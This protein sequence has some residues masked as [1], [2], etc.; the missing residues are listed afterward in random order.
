MYDRHKPIIKWYEYD[1]RKLY[2]TAESE[3]ATEE[4][5]AS[6]VPSASAGPEASAAGE[7]VHGLTDA[8]EDTGSGGGAL[9]GSELDDEV[10]RIMAAFSGAKQNSVD[11]VFAMM[12]AGEG[13]SGEGDPGIDEASG[14][15]S[16]DELLASILAPK[17]NGVDDLVAKAREG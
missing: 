3:D 13:A 6:D 15:A 11:D 9:T 2:Q 4:P 10:A 8:S 1:A 14:A 17:Q 16:E 12:A 5:Q 7:V